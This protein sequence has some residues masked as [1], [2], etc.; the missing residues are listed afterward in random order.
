[1]YISEA[2]LQQNEN[3]WMEE[4]IEGTQGVYNSQEEAQDY[5]EL[6]NVVH[7]ARSGMAYSEKDYLEAE[8]VFE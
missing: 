1:M 8:V 7:A 6:L 5:M 3:V 4:A 2:Q